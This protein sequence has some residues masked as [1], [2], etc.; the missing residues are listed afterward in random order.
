[1]TSSAGALSIAVVKI[2]DSPLNI[3]ATNLSTMSIARMPWT[4][5]AREANQELV[6]R[7]E[8]ETHRHV[9]STLDGLGGRN[10]LRIVTDSSASL[11]MTNEGKSLPAAFDTIRFVFGS[12]RF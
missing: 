6:A 9:E 11:G 8:S 2:R 10:P 3:A 4:Q 1:M 5:S 7:Q 12:R